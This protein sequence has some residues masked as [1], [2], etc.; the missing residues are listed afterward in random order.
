MDEKCVTSIVAV[1]ERKREYTV[2]IGSCAKFAQSPA[3]PAHRLDT[4]NILPM[5]AS[6]ND[7]IW[8]IRYRADENSANQPCGTA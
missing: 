3:M 4:G 6:L 2:L 8:S 7:L 5:E 1:W